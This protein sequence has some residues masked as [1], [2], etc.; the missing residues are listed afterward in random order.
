MLRASHATRLIKKPAG[1]QGVAHLLLLLLLLPLLLLLRRSLRGK[2]D[3]KSV[4]RELRNG[5]RYTAKK[6]LY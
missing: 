5:R 4:D 3:G 6:C 2:R 1:R